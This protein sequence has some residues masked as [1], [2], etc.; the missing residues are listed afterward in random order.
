VWTAGMALAACRV[1]YAGTVVAPRRAAPTV[2]A[3][4]RPVSVSL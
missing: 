4:G 3:V 1:A 2:G